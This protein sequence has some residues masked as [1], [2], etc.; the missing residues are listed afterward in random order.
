MSGG[1]YFKLRGHTAVPSSR[2]DCNAAIGTIVAFDEI[3]GNEIS[4]VFLG[5]N[6]QYD[7]KG[8]PILFETMWISDDGESELIRYSTW[9][10]AEVGHQECLDH[11]RCRSNAPFAI[12]KA[13]AFGSNGARLL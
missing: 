9:E 12:R 7:E 2:E 10:E 3:D 11:I 1:I 8:P 5:I 13:V 4:T 6:R